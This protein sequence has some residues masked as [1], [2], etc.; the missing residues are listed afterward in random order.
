[1]CIHI[2]AIKYSRFSLYKKHSH[3]MIK[4]SLTAT[5]MSSLYINYKFKNLW[6]SFI[7][8]V[9][10]NMEFFKIPPP[11]S[12]SIHND[13]KVKVIIYERPHS[14]F[15]DSISGY[16]ERLLYSTQKIFCNVRG[17]IMKTLCKLN[18]A[19]LL[20]YYSKWHKDVA[21]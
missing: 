2:Y 10:Q 21:I 12:W 15:L 1:M 14:S 4:T 6:G 5:C 16:D 8:D 18:C 13:L 9:Y 3:K 17:G 20:F 19:S 11:L 7:N